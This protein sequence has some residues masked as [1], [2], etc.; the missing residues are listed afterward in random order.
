M[1]KYNII[2]HHTTIQKEKIMT[3]VTTRSSGSSYM[4]RVGLHNGCLSLGHVNTFIPSTLKGSC[5]N[6][7]TGMFYVAIDA[8]IFR[9][10]GI[11]CGDTTIQGCH[12]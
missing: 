5:I 7:E 8:Y 3:L 11:P 6:V 4:N 12:I 9:I 10:D 2:G 1:T